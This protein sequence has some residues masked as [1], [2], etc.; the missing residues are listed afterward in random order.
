MT[1]V[2]KTETLSLQFKGVFGRNKKEKFETLTLLEG[3]FENPSIPELSG[4]E[5]NKLVE[6]KLAEVK[7]KAG[8]WQ[9]VRYPVQ[10][11]KYVSD[12]GKEV[13]MKSV[14]LSLISR[15]VVAKGTK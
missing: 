8:S 7:L 11:E 10:L 3:S 5:L 9:V 1:N 15:N 2:I 6:E 13:I 14:T 12:S 4:E